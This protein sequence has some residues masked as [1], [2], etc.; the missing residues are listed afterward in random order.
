MAK[1]TTPA[2]P[3][4][5]TDTDDPRNAASAKPAAAP[6][7][8]RP[9]SHRRGGGGRYRDHRWYVDSAGRRYWSV[10]TLLK[11]L[12]KD[13]LVGWAARVTAEAAIDNIDL[14]GQHARQLGRDAAV[15]ALRDVR[16]QP[17]KVAID[18]G[19]VVHAA[20]NRW[21]LEQPLPDLINDVETRLVLQFLDFLER[22]RPEPYATEMVVFNASQWYAGTLDMIMRLPRLPGAPLALIDVK[23]GS[24]V[25]PETC[26]QL[27]AYR[28]AEFVE[29]GDGRELPMP[30]V[31]TCMVL[32]LAVDPDGPTD[33]DRW[34]LVPVETG[35]VRENNGNPRDLFKTFLFVREVYRFLNELSVSVIG[36]PMPIP[37]LGDEQPTM[38]ELMTAAAPDPDGD[39]AKPAQD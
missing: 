9:R 19:K 6:T 2:A 13:A 35:A 20:I 18:R 3:P 33:D 10:T 1:R 16:F 23:T 8:S 12:P 17:N 24:G 26:L 30:A 32:H 31:D 22:H 5:P 25:Y 39:D 37:P 15:S 38:V 21:L 11:A 29:I 4:P 36:A 27:T 28:N 34:D 14:W 7:T